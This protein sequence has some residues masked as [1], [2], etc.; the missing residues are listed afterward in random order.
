MLMENSVDAG[1]AYAAIQHWELIVSLFIPWVVAWLIKSEWAQATQAAVMLA[2]CGIVTTITMYLQ[3]DLAADM[4]L[5]TSFLKVVAFTI[6]YYKGIW[7]P[8]QVAPNIEA[9]MPSPLPG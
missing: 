5:V 4:D 8:T 9:K 7:K 2:V 6:V 3:G 1:T